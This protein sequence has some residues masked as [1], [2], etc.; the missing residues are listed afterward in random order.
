MKTFGPQVFDEQED[1]AKLTSQWLDDMEWSTL[2]SPAY[3]TDTKFG[4]E[5]FNNNDSSFT[6][7]L[8]SR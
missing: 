8:H 1:K 6:N 7:L 4:S 2:P 3:G 5:Y